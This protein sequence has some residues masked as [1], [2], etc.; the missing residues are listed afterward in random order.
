MHLVLS[1][2]LH[3]C[4]SA[5]VSDLRITQSSAIPPHILAGLNTNDSRRRARLRTHGPAHAVCGAERSRPGLTPHGRSVTRSVSPLPLV[6]VVES[7]LCLFSR[8][9]CEKIKLFIVLQ[10]EDE[11]LIFCLCSAAFLQ[12]Q[13]RLVREKERDARQSE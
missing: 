11:P 3:L 7:E 8:G 1:G 5:V 10:N 9:S 2:G 6:K 12:L 13:Q 4:A